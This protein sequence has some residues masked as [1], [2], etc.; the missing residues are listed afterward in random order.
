VNTS[1]APDDQ[2]SGAPV[3][4]PRRRWRATAVVVAVVAVAVVTALV[5]ASRG[6]SSGPGPTTRAIVVSA[7]PVGT[8]DL[9][10]VPGQLTIVAA[11]TNRV[12]LTGQL[13]W[14]RHAPI[15]SDVLDRSSR[16]L[17]LSYRCA[18]A[19]PCT[20]NY[21]LVVP[22][23]TAVVLRQPA[24]QVVIS[25]LAGPLDIIAAS[26]DISATGLRSP[27]LAVAIVS[28][29]L[30][31]TFDLPP[32]R[33]SVTLTSAQATLQLPASTSYNVSSQVTAGYVHVGIPQSSRAAR[34]IMARIS[35]GELELLPG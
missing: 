2:G 15:V 24:G 19:S 6:G 14:S 28:G 22:V 32:Q 17:H 8:V 29:H 26:V 20:E 11:A 3:P 12:T 33:V 27:S 21:R 25:G 4:A 23:R 16:V 9:Q 7:G 10:G 13:H 31:A 5:A 35:S 34:T 1:P 18:P 30:G